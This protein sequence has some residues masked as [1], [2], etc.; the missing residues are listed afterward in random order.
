MGSIPNRLLVRYLGTRLL[1]LHVKQGIEPLLRGG[2][3]HVDLAIWTL[4][5]TR[6]KLAPVNSC[7]WSRALV[8]L[9]TT[10]EKQIEQRKKGRVG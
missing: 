4:G 6:D 1:G 2:V 5:E 9:R 8:T 7:M 10:H 3:L